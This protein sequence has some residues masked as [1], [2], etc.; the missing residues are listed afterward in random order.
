M[1]VA[2]GTYA[3][4]GAA[5]E[6]KTLSQARVEAVQA[7][8]VSLGVGAP[9]LSIEAPG[10]PLPACKGKDAQ[11]V[12]ECKANGQRILAHVTAK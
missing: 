12:E 10:R 4:G 6:A 3:G 2:L 7:A 5:A 8:L 11:A 9:R 1:K